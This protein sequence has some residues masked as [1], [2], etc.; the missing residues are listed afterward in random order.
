[1]ADRPYIQMSIVEL[2]NLVKE[3]R[4]D[5]A[6]LGPIRVELENRTTKRARQLLREVQGLVAGEIPQNKTSLPDVPENQIELPESR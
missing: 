4:S 6:V 3:R 5:M 1:M 2:E